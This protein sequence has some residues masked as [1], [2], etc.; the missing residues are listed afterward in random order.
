MIVSEGIEELLVVS[1]AFLRF[2]LAWMATTAVE[3]QLFRATKPRT[4]CSYVMMIVV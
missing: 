2:C 1:V 3:F 4:G